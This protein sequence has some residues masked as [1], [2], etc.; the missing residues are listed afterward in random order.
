MAKMTDE[1]ERWFHAGEPDDGP[2]LHLIEDDGEEALP[3]LDEPPDLDDHHAGQ[4]SPPDYDT[5]VAKR[6]DWLRIT[7]EAQRRLDA[8][9]RPALTLPPIQPFTEW[10]SRPVTPVRYRIDKL[11]PTNARV[12]LC[13]AWKAGKTAIVGNLGRALADNTPFLDHFAINTPTHHLVI[14]DD[15]LDED[16]LHAW[17]SAQNITN[18]NA[19]AE[20]I[21]LRGRVSSLNILDDHIRDMW[22]QRLRDQGCDYLI[23]DCLR[24]VLDACG[25]DEAHDAGQFLIA[26]DELIAQAAV[27]DSTVVHHMGHT[28]ERSRGDSRLLDWPDVL[29]KIVR[30]DPDNPASA[31][32]FSAYGRGVDVYEGRLTYDP[33]NHH[34]T[35]VGGTRSDA[36][37]EAAILA[38][39]TLLAEEASP[40]GE[41]LSQTAIES[42]VNHPRQTVRDAI[43]QAIRTGWVSRTKKGRARLHRITNPCGQCGMP[44]ASG[45]PRHESC[46][47]PGKP[48]GEGLLLQ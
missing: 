12:L 26:Y 21:P 38:V 28:N 5:R 1:G 23:T 42:T 47:K 4:W 48:L 20:V 2:P 39:I 16:M 37:T 36:K 19:I 17:L 22:V 34:I 29:W 3:E 7:Q 41:G 31:R 13:A 33:G 27:G 45:R 6:L 15:E 11:A 10:I 30:A 32:Y 40:E 25:L 9:N 43:K 8:E 14:I 46:P 44:V 35:Y 18:T 24:P